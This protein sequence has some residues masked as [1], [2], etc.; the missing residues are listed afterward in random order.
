MKL[1]GVLNHHVAHR[2]DSTCTLRSGGESVLHA[3]AKFHLETVLRSREDLRAAIPLLE[4]CTSCPSYPSR[5]EVLWGIPWDEVRVEMA[6]GNRRPDVVLL[7]AGLPVAAIE[8]LVHHAVDV[9]KA[10]DLEDL[11]I[12]WIEVEALDILGTVADRDEDTPPWNGNHPLRV[13][14]QSDPVPW[15][16]P[17][18]LN[19]QKEKE[20]Q[21]DLERARW[22]AEA[23]RREEAL[24]LDTLAAVA[25]MKA[26]AAW[27]SSAEQRE[28]RRNAQREADEAQRKADEAQREADGEAF[29]ADLVAEFAAFNLRL[30]TQRRY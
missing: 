24:R 15:V 27:E 9:D 8:V 18:C 22:E 21:R 12:P 4:G 26:S 25:A 17:R 28:A 13:A 7:Q 19:L 3:N 5:H 2:P 10:D 20:R 29:L 11:G 1:G 16:C 6:T 30:K 14:A 23:P